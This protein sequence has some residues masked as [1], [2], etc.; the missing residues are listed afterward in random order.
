MSTASRLLYPEISPDVLASF[1]GRGVTRTYGK[2]TV[3]I[4]EGDTSHSFYV[5]VEGK[6]KVFVSDEDGKEVV[7]NVQS[8]GDCF[9][10]LALIDEA[11]R[12]ASVM[13]L[14]RS[15]I[16]VI[17]AAEFYGC[18]A[19]N[20]EAAAWFMRSMARRVRVLTDNVKSLALQDVYGRI[21][22]ALSEL[23]SERNGDLVVEQ[24]LTH[25]ELA[26]I[27]GASRE[28]VSRVM[29]ELRLG[30]YVTVEDRRIVIR[31]S[32]PRSL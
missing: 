30:G 22:R 10:E 19:Q 26:N 6:V 1:A 25:Q 29:K 8:A 12:S 24:R 4:S 7:V 31:R 2:N 15:K 27:V 16:A 21:T 3:L 28:M 23:A 32:L 11:P 20:P 17:P 18:L 9:G 5:I 13:T 14:E